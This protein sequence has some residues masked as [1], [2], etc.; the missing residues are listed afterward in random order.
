MIISELDMLRQETVSR[1][2]GTIG[3]TRS[4]NINDD[5]SVNCNGHF[6][7]VEMICRWLYDAERVLPSSLNARDRSIDL[8]RTASAYPDQ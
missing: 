4:D 6:M 1:D 8:N 5:G 2:F 7:K 3:G